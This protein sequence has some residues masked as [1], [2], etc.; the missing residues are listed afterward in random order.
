MLSQKQLEIKYL[1]FLINA[2]LSGQVLQEADPEG[3]RSMQEASGAALGVSTA[4]GRGRER[5]GTGQKE[6]LVCGVRTTETPA[7]L[8]GSCRACLGQG[9]GACMSPKPTGHGMRLPQE[10][11]V[12]VS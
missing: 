5:C 2:G 4:G 8:Q 11:E 10:G 7:D 3:K 6:E 12:A 9:D 1:S